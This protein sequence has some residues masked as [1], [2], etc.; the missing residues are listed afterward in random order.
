MLR[1][2]IESTNPSSEALDQAIAE[3]KEVG[4]NTPDAMTGQLLQTLA[5]TTAAQ[6]LVAITP[7]ADV[8]GLYML[9][10]ASD[11]SVLT[12]IDPEPE[13]QQR[14]KAIFRSAGYPGQRVRFLPSRPLEVLGR[15]AKN[16]YQVIYAEVSPIDLS[17]L[18]DAALPLLS[19]GGVLLLADALLDGTISDSSRID[20][21]TLAAREADEHILALEGVVVARLPLGAGLTMITKCHKS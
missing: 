9:A 18:V 3:A 16:S 12:C 2:Y 7:A 4:L 15:L 21:D 13:H 19:E 14:A 11:K 5:A 1:E 10:G 20:R 17:A 6:G 8:A